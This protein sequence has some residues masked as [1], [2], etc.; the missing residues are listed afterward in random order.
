M[1]RHARVDLKDPKC[2]QPGWLSVGVI[3]VIAL[4][5]GVGTAQLCLGARPA[6][7]PRVAMPAPAAGANETALA[8]Q[9][10]EPAAAQATSTPRPEPGDAR[11][12]GAAGDAAIR[13][14]AARIAGSLAVPPQP[15]RLAPLPNTRHLTRGRVAYV[16]CDG[17]ELHAGHF[18]CP[19]DRALELSVWTALRG[20]EHC[21]QAGAEHGEAEVR[22]E[23]GS[24]AP[25]T[26]Q[27]RPANVD[28]LDV[29][30]V[31]SCVGEALSA[32]RTLLRPE[33]M[34]I[35]FGFSLR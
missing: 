34:V 12:A 32:A 35:S 8:L 27:V 29:S 6:A 17:L 24:S 18:P 7:S 31:T 3:A 5:L 21:E 19:R 33:R 30:A 26:V 4:G 10:R 2:D 22:L 11:D 16:R 15:A 25:T 20:L 9:P 28:S 1:S 23:F 13:A 14:D